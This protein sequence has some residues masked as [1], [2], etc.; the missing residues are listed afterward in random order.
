[1][2][3]AELK[4]MR[5]VEST[6]KLSMVVGAI[7]ACCCAGLIIYLTIGASSEGGDSNTATAAR[8]DQP[9][10]GQNLAGCNGLTSS[11]AC[12]S[13]TNQ[14]AGTAEQSPTTLPPT[15]GATDSPTTSPTTFSPTRQPTNAPTSN[16]TTL[17]PTSQPTKSPTSSPTATPYFPGDL[18]MNGSE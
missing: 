10:N 12:P 5:C 8:G 7:V 4:K 15:V 2:R 14:D 1:M 13:Q 17:H 6:A 3:C 18:R 9:S 11:A 16:P